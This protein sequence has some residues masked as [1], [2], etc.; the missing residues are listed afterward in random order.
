MI[1]P[2]RLIKIIATSR[3]EVTHSDYLWLLVKLYGLDYKQAEILLM[4][5]FGKLTEG[6]EE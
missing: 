5:E 6:E 1:K 4:T 3:E 2:N